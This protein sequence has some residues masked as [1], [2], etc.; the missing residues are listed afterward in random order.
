MFEEGR[1][2]FPKIGCHEL[3]A[4]LTGFGKEKHDDLVDA[5]T[6]V[7][8]ELVKLGSRPVPRVRTI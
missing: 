2:L 5:I 7:V 8:T 4:Q 3:I 6:I 1:V